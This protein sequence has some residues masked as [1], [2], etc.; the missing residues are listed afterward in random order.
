MRSP[1]HRNNA[2][3]PDPSSGTRERQIDINSANDADWID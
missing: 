1:R 3:E 2:G